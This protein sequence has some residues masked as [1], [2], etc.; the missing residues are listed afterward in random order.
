MTWIARFYGPLVSVTKTE[1]YFPL[2]IMIVLAAV[3]A[4]PAFYAR[5]L[6]LGTLLALV[7]FAVMYTF[8]AGMLHTG[9]T[10]LAIQVECFMLIALFCV[11][12]VK[13]FNL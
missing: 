11:A 2:V 8:Q 3:G 9:T 7:C 5:G 12:Q 10:I 6:F 1:A 13:F 4:S